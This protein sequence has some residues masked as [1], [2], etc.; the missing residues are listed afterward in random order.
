MVERCPGCGF[1]FERE[2]GHWIGALGM[3][4]VISFGTLLATIVVGI[5][6]TAPDIAV[7]PLTLAAT[8]A[9]LF[10]PVLAFPFTRTLWSAIDL[11]MRPLEPGELPPTRNG[12][13]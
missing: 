3:N 9:A 5:V 7:A 4:T 11:M 8:A 6:L 13:P 10:V 12:A 1:R 2:S